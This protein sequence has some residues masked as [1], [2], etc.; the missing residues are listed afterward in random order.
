M[1]DGDN[2]V[3]SV[4]AWQ[5]VAG[6]SDARAEPSVIRRNETRQGPNIRERSSLPRN[7]I[8]I[9]CEM[10]ALKSPSMESELSPFAEVVDASRRHAEDHISLAESFCRDFACCGL[11]LKT[12]HD[13]VEHFETH[14]VVIDDAF[15]SNDVYLMPSAAAA[16]AATDA[17]S[18]DGHD[19]LFGGYFA[20]ALKSPLAYGASLL[21]QQNNYNN[22]NHN[23]SQK[24][25]DF[26]QYDDT[27]DVAFDTTILRPAKRSRSSSIYEPNSGDEDMHH[28]L[29]STG[30]HDTP[31]Y[32]R[33]LQFETPPPLTVSPASLSGGSDEDEFVDPHGPES[34]Y[35]DYVKMLKQKEKAMREMRAEKGERKYE[36]V[37]PGCTR[38]YRNQNGLKYHIMHSHNPEER[39]LAERL[40]KAVRHDPAEKPFACHFPGC[41]KRYR[42]SNGLK[43]HLEHYHLDEDDDQ[44]QYAG[45]SKFSSGS[46]I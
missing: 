41:G 19:A 15:E 24:R 28:T 35:R 45:P 40:I 8:S 14:H 30:N 6:A 13:L 39:E 38:V 46:L 36:C 11:A 3:V 27:D 31:Y 4:Y 21:S 44:R 18:G 32:I 5:G 33:Q 20:S 25:S 1:I 16:V 29:Y 9:C 42:N 43:Y 10:T 22:S 17:L 26:L 37:V 23:H 2:S 12:M 34:A 7:N